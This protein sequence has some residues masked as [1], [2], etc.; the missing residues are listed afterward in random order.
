MGIELGTHWTQADACPR[1]NLS[2][3]ATRLR[4]MDALTDLVTS[5]LPQV[6]LGV[7]AVVGLLALYPRHRLAG[8]GLV[9][10]TWLFLPF[11][12]RILDVVFG[13]TEVDVISVLPFALTALAGMFEL[14]RHRPSRVALATLTVAA[15]AFLVG[16][17]AGLDQ[18]IPLLF[19]L[20]SYGGAMF[21]TAIGYAD[22]R[23]LPEVPL[24]S[25]GWAL[26]AAAPVIGAYAVLQY[27][28]LEALPW[29]TTW[30]IGTDLRS[31]ASPE[32]GRI[33]AFST[34]N[35]P[36][37]FAA[38]VAVAAAVILARPK[39]GPYLVAGAFLSAVALT[40]TFVR[41]VWV[42]FGVA[43]VVYLVAHASRVLV[44]RA[45][46]A[47]G[48][49]IAI[50]V[51]GWGHPTIQAVLARGASVVTYGDDTS[52]QARFRFIQSVLPTTVSPEGIA[53]HGLGQSGASVSIGGAGDYLLA[54]HGYVSFLYQNGPVGLALLL[55]A[56][57]SLGLLA[58]RNARRAVWHAPLELAIFALFIVIGFFGDVFYGVIGAMF[59]YVA[60]RI[61]AHADVSATPIAITGRSSFES[62]AAKPTGQPE[63]SH[64]APHSV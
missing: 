29:D 31:L 30:I 6:V 38:V 63:A 52:A 20:I 26:T 39:L 15:A 16:V 18:P 35:S 54:D 7:V 28:Y 42:A 19:G 12:R 61:L 59:W 55:V 23:R 37:P 49:A 22:A 64:D 62:A 33:R 58:V 60:G 13:F 25:L 11:V 5:Q 46:A 43:A 44:V 2:K 4:L 27:Y 36:L 41:S 1:P 47:A 24:G 53:G 32:P 40:L 8:L 50:V 48:V 21:A 51:I 34:L 45:A 14:R 57:A 56:L 10:G 17:P 3:N 9:W